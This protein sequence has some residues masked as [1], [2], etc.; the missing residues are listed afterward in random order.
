W[1]ALAQKNDV[2]ALVEHRREPRRRLVVDRRG[3]RGGAQRK[4]D[5][6]LAFSAI[7]PLRDDTARE[8]GTSLRRRVGADRRGAQQ[9]QCLQCQEFG[10]A[11]PN[12]DAVELAGEL[13]GHSACPTS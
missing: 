3:R 10:V 12:A 9:P 11:G 6:D 7:E 13:T 4:A 2:V 8:A 5:R 1:I